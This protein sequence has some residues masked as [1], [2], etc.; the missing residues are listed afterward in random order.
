MAQTSQTKPKKVKAS[1]P[2][3]TAP[4]TA[5]PMT[6]GQL[7]K[8]PN[9][10]PKQG[11][12][13][14]S[15]VVGKTPTSPL[16]GKTLALQI[17]DCV[18]MYA[19]ALLDP[20]NTEAGVCIP[21]E[22]F[23]IPS[24]KAKLYRRGR[25]NL[26]TTGFGYILVKPDTSND[27]V[28]INTTTSSSVGGSGTALSAFSFLT[29]AAF[30]Q[31]PYATAAFAA[32]GIIS[33]I[34]AIG[35]RVKYIDKLMN[36]NG[37]CCGFED[38]DHSDV[39]SK[40]YD[41]LL[42]SPYS[43]PKRIGDD[44]WDMSIC[45]SGPVN[46]TDV[47]FVS[48]SATPLGVPS[49]LAIVLSGVAGDQYEYEVVEHVEY[50]GSTVVNKT[51]S[52]ADAELFGKVVET[53]KTITVDRPLQP[54]EAPS[55]WSSLGEAFESTLPKIVNIGKGI[56]SGASKGGLMGGLF[57]G[58]SSALGMA[59]G[60]RTDDGFLLENS[61]QK[62][63]AMAPIS[64]GLNPGGRTFASHELKL[65]SK[66]IADRNKSDAKNVKYVAIRDDAR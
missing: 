35:I 64:F 32:G 58:I 31:S 53:A 41:T 50:A 57:G 29:G 2:L 44:E 36:R 13:V 65:L 39:S 63:I 38:P 20:F 19:D 28:A 54:E 9:M 51:P 48:G 6:N 26:G 52:H 37:M 27:G 10:A 30:A 8:A 11:I 42:A 4:P 66:K 14:H 60:R 25:F 49:F 55:F 62:K 45:Y 40:S 22:L 46:P 34:A 5:T 23:P 33:R 18:M 16:I 1:P 15:N 56:F 7:G 3:R 12:V 21:S 47:D 59:P 17:P 24:S 61:G 43:M